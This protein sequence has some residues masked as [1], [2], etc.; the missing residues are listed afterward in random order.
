MHRVGV[1]AAAGRVDVGKLGEKPEVS[2]LVEVLHGDNVV[3]GVIG[4]P[5]E[6]QRVWQEGAVCAIVVAP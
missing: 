5:V 2:I 6:E 3:F 4:S 1:Q